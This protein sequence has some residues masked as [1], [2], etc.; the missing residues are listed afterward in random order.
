MLTMPTI[1]TMLAILIEARWNFAYVASHVADPRDISLYVWGKGHSPESDPPKPSEGDEENEEGDQTR[2]AG[3]L[4]AVRK[5]AAELAGATVGIVSFWYVSGVT[6]PVLGLHTGITTAAVVSCAVGVLTYCL[7]RHYNPSSQPVEQAY[8]AAKRAARAA[9][10]KKR[11]SRLH[12]AHHQ[13][14]MAR[15]A[16]CAAKTGA[17]MATARAKKESAVEMM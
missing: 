4:S 11:A 17:K 14:S 15:K 10:V 13:L 9:G 16:A 2:E 8:R 1:L 12:W 7:G 3:G 5:T 6:I